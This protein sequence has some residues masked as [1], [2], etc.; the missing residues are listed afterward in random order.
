MER[1]YFVLHIL[2]IFL[3]MASLGSAIVHVMNGGDKAS[4]GSRRWL[5]ITH[6]VSMLVIL[7]AGVGMLKRGG[8][9]FSEGWVHGK[10]GVWVVL[11]IA[12]TLIYRL[13][14]LGRALWFIVPLLGAVAAYFAKYKLY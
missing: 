6:G 10:L 3:V 14:G 5:A 8:W 13:P 9:S 7:V 12:P 4:N 1:V 2:G 11:G